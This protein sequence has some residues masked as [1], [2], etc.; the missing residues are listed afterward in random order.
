MTAE[1]C[2]NRALPEPDAAAMA[3]ARA[4]QDQLTKPPG[5]L[6]RLEAAA[7]ELCGQQATDRPAV[8]RVRIAVFA[9]DHGVCA[10]GISAFPQTVTGQM[11]ANFAAGGAA[12]SVLARQLGAGLDVINLGTVNELPALPG[13]RDQR[14]GPGTA[15]FVQGPAMTRA[16]LEAALQAGD[17]A[18]QRAL[19]DGAQLFIGGDMGIGN[20]TSA[21]ALACALLDGEPEA[22]AGPGTGLDANGVSHKA[23]V[24]ARALAHHRT[25]REPL[26]L[27]AALGGFEIAGLTGAMLGCAARRIPVLVDG[28]I[29]SVAALVAV[30]HAPAL[31]PWLHFG[32]RSGEPGHGQVLAALSAEPLLDLAMRL[33][34]GS[35]AA[36]AVPLLRSA[37][38]LHNGM[39]SFA[40]AGVDDGH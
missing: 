13:V 37:C 35:G 8:D 3:R 40:D 25:T 7:I 14:I 20:T 39:A 34:E 16:Q 6:G 24:I 36:V 38:A 19:D 23:R 26:A 9:A 10:E 4:R 33:G 30:R 27:L 29:V 5:S 18:A 15:N 32:H 31:R 1:P 11:V 17:E 22:L 2:W 21:A 12:I 28:F